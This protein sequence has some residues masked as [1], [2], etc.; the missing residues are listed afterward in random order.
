MAVKV[1]SLLFINLRDEIW[2]N[3]ILCQPFIMQA[4]QSSH[5]HE[6]EEWTEYYI[7]FLKSLSIRL[8]EAQV[9]LF[10]NK[11]QPLRFRRAALTR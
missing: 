5:N 8:T 11:V 10:Y 6:E 2:V 4:I 9:S 7:S 1:L 3:F